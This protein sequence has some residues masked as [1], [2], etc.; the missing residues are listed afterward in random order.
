MRNYIILNGNNSNEITGLLIQSLPPISKP[1]MRTAIEEIDGRD[2][3]IVTNLGYSAYDKEVS[4]GLYGSYD[5]DEV[6][7]YFSDNSKGQVTFSNEPDKYYNYEI[8]NQIDFERLIR[9]K[10]AIVTLHCQPFKYP[11]NET[12]VEIAYQYINNEAEEMALDNTANAPM[13]LGFKGQIQQDS[14]TGKNLLNLKTYTYGGITSTYNDDTGELS[15]VGTATTGYPWLSNITLATS[16]PIG[17]I[18]TF[19]IQKPSPYP[20]VIRLYDANNTYEAIS[21]ST[22]S[23]SAT[24]TTTKEIILLRILVGYGEGTSV[25]ESN[26]YQLEIGNSATN[27]EKFTNGASPNPD[28][29]QPIHSVS[30]DNEIKVCNK[31]L[32]D[33]SLITNQTLNG[34]TITSNEGTII[35]NGTSTSAFAINIPIN[36]LE[37][38]TIISAS[39]NNNQIASGVQLR[40][41]QQESTSTIFAGYLLDEINK[42]ME[43]RTLPQYSDLYQ[44]RIANGITLTNFVIKPMLE[45]GS[46]ATSYVEHQEYT[47]EINLGELEVGGIGEYEDEFFK[48]T[49]DSEYYDSTLLQDKWYLHKETGKYV[50][51]SFDSKSGTSNNYMYSTSVIDNIKKPSSGATISDIVSSHFVSKAPNTIYANDTTGIGI[52]TNGTIACAFGLASGLNTKELANEWLSNNNVVVVYPLATPE[53]ILLNDTLQEQLDDLRNNAR[54]FE[55][56][57]HITQ[58]A[59][60]KPFMLNATAVQKG[61]DTGI[62]DNDGNI[63]SKPTL[64]IEGT[65]T[66]GIYLN[67]NQMFSVDMSSLNECIIDVTN[68]EAYD[69]STNELMNRQVT[70]DYSKFT[71]PVGENEV[72]VSGN[73]TKA[74]ISNYVRWL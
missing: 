44:I 50:I 28:Y 19:S 36:R 18:L 33:T 65:G 67:D 32:L 23:T 27:F 29:P 46:T 4:I 47:K 64:D 9:F 1:L 11:V 14:T 12:P 7:K 51:T 39:A 43:N 35:L 62:V 3:D 8:I 57:T 20:I 17:T 21:I 63:Y 70:G 60:D 13:T 56:R 24:K 22:G 31:N 48:N 52:N 5:V 71:L 66:V 25:N 58:N 72:K 45:L 53:N 68:L 49:T 30:G 73:V 41:S 10:T 6:I 74:T 61:T 37:A 40:F 38:N 15:S 26:F 42:K 59:N 69:P 34:V 55:D 2:G 54:S 16:I